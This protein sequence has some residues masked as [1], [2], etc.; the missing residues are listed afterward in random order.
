MIH[1]DSKYVLNKLIP[2]SLFLKH[3]SPSLIERGQLD[4]W[5]ENRF[6]FDI[7]TDLDFVNRFNGLLE[8][9][10]TAIDLNEIFLDLKGND[11]DYDLKI[12]D[13]FAEIHFT[14]WAHHNGFINIHKIPR[15]T[16]KT[17]DFTM[18]DRNGKKIVIEVKHVRSG[19]PFHD[20]A[21]EKAK[22]L[23]LINELIDKIGLEIY[24]TAKYLK[25]QHRILAIRNIYYILGPKL[26]QQLSGNKVIKLSDGSIM[27]IDLLN[28]LLKVKASEYAGFSLIDYDMPDRLPEPIHIAERLLK[29]VNTKKEQISKYINLFVT[30]SEAKKISEGIIFITG[31]SNE[32]SFWW[33][34]YEELNEPD[35]ELWETINCI[36]ADSCPVPIRIISNFGGTHDNYYDFPGNYE[37]YLIIRKGYREITK[38]RLNTF[39]PQQ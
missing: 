19:N 38:Q 1:F 9:A 11:K 2:F 18:E 17:P 28:N 20:L 3:V 23:L 16:T 24:E 22:G 15:S 12:F 25:Y 13:I 29:E 7:Y 34:L 27:E 39:L 4:N 37:E 35:S 30:D 32:E 36:Y 26:R 14:V 21:N 6:L 33:L 5:Y 10:S 8:K 31:I